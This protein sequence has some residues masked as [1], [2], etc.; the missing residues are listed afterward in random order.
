[1]EAGTHI[2]TRIKMEQEFA[3]FGLQI[4]LK[5][6]CPISNNATDLDFGRQTEVGNLMKVWDWLQWNVWGNDFMRGAGGGIITHK[7]GH[8]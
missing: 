8:C 1:M 6:A 7:F 2:E 3:L 5:S 4:H